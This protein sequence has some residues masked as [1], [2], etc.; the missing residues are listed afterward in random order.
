M[1]KRKPPQ[2]EPPPLE[3]TLDGQFRDPP[4]VPVVAQ[5]GRLAIVVAVM[6]TAGAVA[7][8]ALWFAL[9]LIPIALGAGLVA[10]GVLRYQRWR[11]V[12]IF[13]RPPGPFG[14][15]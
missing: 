10:Y 7:L 5:I 2:Y 9:A 14:G 11:G 1:E 15:R 3:M 12:G 13:A 8:L 4:A 6:A